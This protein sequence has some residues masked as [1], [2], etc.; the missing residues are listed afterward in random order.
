MSNAAGKAVVARRG[1]GFKYF[2][3][4]AFRKQFISRR[5]FRSQCFSRRVYG[6]RVYGSVPLLLM[7]R[8]L[9]ISESSALT[10]LTGVPTVPSLLPPIS[11]LLQR[12]VVQGLPTTPKPMVACTDTQ[13][14]PV[15][16][17]V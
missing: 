4:R 11:T 8:L 2:G 13:T 15:Q 14:E 6:C 9:C 16:A 1:F 7:L 10:S 17:V 3:W 12:S 5:A